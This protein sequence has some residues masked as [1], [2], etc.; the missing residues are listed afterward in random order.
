[1]RSVR[2][3]VGCRRRS[4]GWC[5]VELDAAGRPRGVQSTRRSSAS[6]RAT[7]R[8]AWRPR[9]P[10]RD[11]RRRCHRRGGRSRR[12]PSGRRARPGQEKGC[13]GEVLARGLVERSALCLTS[14]R[15]TGLGHRS[16]PGAGTAHASRSWRVSVAIAVTSPVL[17]CRPDKCPFS[18]TP[19]GLRAARRRAGCRAVRP[20]CRDSAP[21]RL[22]LYNARFVGV[23][24]TSQQHTDWCQDS[25]RP[26]G[27]GVSFAD[28]GPRRIVAAGP[29][30]LRLLA[31]ELLVLLEDLF[32]RTVHPQLT[33]LQ[34]EHAVAGVPDR[35]VVVADQ[36]HRARA[37]QLAGSAPRSAWKERV[38]S[39]ASS[40]MRTSWSL[41]AAMEKRSR[42]AMPE[43]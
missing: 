26:A 31:R 21:V 23:S 30:V 36:K 3:T 9:R 15:R 13:H 4:S 29:C 16:P 33:A 34:P 41:A 20:T 25:L 18:D 19:P 14:A 40:I 24:C 35:L 37:A 8:A 42:A 32:G 5:G 1:M 38:A 22:T 7:R 43:E 12:R 17:H 27:V 39:R 28:A 6:I 10:G 2:R 11:R